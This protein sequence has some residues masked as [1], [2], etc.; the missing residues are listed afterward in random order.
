[1]YSNKIV[2]SCDRVS[3]S[4]RTTLDG[5]RVAVFYTKIHGRLLRPLLDASDQPPAP[6]ELT[7]ALRT[8]DR[9]LTDYIHHARLG[10]AA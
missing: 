5:I 3:C 8:I 4:Y 6:I 1:M 9:T 2:R 7:R 10:T